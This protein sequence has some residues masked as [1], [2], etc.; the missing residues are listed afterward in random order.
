M[1]IFVLLGT[2][3]HGYAQA[4]VPP[5]IRATYTIDALTDTDRMGLQDMVYGIP[6]EPGKVIG[7]T[8]LETHWK[9][10]NILLY[11]KEQLIKNYPVRYDIRLDEVEVKSRDGV[12]VLKGTKIKSFVWIDSVSRVRSYF[13]NAKD[14]KN[15]SNVP[16]TG[17]FQVLVDGSLPLLKKTLIEI[18]KADYNIQMNVGSHDDKILKKT[19]YYTLIDNQVVELPSGKKKLIAMFPDKVEA[20][21]KFIKD[22][23][24]TV[25]R[26]DHLALIFTHYNSLENN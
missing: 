26:E 14:F 15:E 5:N 18:K 7:D 16:Y 12:K 24:L 22:S 19:E 13:I 9:T 10:A 25:S 4:V 2:I 3:S 11:E 6:M 8:Y 23:D 17:F 20:V 21:E 1:S